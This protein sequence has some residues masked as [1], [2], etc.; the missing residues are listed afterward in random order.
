MGFSLLAGTKKRRYIYAVFCYYHLERRSRTCFMNSTL[1]RCAVSVA[2]GSKPVAGFVEFWELVLATLLP[3]S[4]VRGL[5][6][7]IGIFYKLGG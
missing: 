3:E 4:V 1:S 2:A 6:F 7:S 5:L